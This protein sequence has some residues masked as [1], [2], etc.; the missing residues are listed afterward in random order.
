MT[1]AN[2]TERIET[3]LERSDEV[4]VQVMRLAHGT[5]LALPVYK[6]DGAAGADIRAALPDDAPLIL[7]PGARAAVP[8][9]LCL[10]IP[11]GFEVQIRP[12][13]GLARDHGVTMV[14]TPGTIDSDYRGEVQ[15][16]LIN[17]GQEPV[18]LERGDR[19]AQ[20]VLAPVT[21]I[22]WEDVPAL[23]DTERGAG[24]FGSTGRG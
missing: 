12:R 11:P 10:A 19:I 7:E 17:L 16:L 13:S 15:V 3:V 2:T 20:M 8:T 4:S 18:T 23:E 1:A 14:N 6:T 21:R 5:D 22:A 9:G 24:G